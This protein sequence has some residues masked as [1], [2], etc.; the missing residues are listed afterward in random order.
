MLGESPGRL[1]EN[2]D[3]LLNLNDPCALTDTAWI[4]PGKAIREA[5]LSTV[6]AKA[7]VDFAVKHNL[8]YIEFDAGWYGHEYSDA[9][10]AS[11]VALDAAR[12]SKIPNH[13]GL[14]LPVVIRYARERGV[15]VWLYVNSR[16]LERQLDVLLPLYKSWGV[17]GIKYGFVNVGTQKATAWLHEAI[18]KTAAHKLMVDVHDEYCPTGWSRTYPNLLTQEGIHG[19]EEAPANNVTLDI[20]FTRMLAGAADNTICYYD[21]RVNRNA[22]HAYQLAKAV[23]FYSPLQFLYWYDRPFRS[24]GAAGRGPDGPNILGDEPEL[25]FFDAVPTVWDD[26]KVLHGEI[27]EYGILARRSGPDWFIGFMNA[28][29]PRHFEVP[30]TFLAAGTRY[31]A[32]LYSDDPTIPTRTQIRIERFMVDRE[33]VLTLSASE[34][35]GQAVR[36]V[37]AKDNDNYPRYTPASGG[38]FAHPGILHTKADLERIREKAT[39]GAEPW[40][41]GFDRLRS[42]LISCRVVTSPARYSNA[43]AV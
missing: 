9:S 17:A 16:A 6:G 33:T 24:P 10:D 22:T 25:E 35:G 15:G 23:C 36:I 5:S 31:V 41:V 7:C 4:K 40:K 12:V 1:L 28:N 20:L 29:Q 38:A 8:Q 14:D 42:H 34:K 13:G 26:T 37:P 32:L 11:G 18:R 27:G 30:L 21:G 2:N 39:G 19:D 3:L 43:R